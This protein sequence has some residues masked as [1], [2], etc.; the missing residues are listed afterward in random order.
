MNG[1]LGSYSGKNRNGSRAND[2]FTTRQLKVM[3]IYCQKVFVPVYT[4]SRIVIA[5]V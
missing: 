4:V 3:P 1:A 5:A 2:G